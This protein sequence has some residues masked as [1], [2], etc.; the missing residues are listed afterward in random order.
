MTAEYKQVKKLVDTGQPVIFVTG[1][2]G[3]GKSTL[4][5][6]LRNIIRGNCVVLA[7]T[8]NWRF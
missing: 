3:T 1:K 5:R 4:I 2:A 7:P 8:M 6:Y